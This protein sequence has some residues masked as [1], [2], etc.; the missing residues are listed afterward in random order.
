MAAHNTIKDLGCEV[1][2]DFL[3]AARTCVETRKPDGSILGYPATLILLA[4]MDA[5]G[6]GLSVGK[7]HTRLVVLLHPPF[8]EKLAKFDQD[9]SERPHV[10]NLTKWY[11][12]M[13]AHSGLIAPGVAL[14]P[15]REGAPFGFTGGE[16]TT[17]RVPVLYELVRDVW[18]ELKHTFTPRFCFGEEKGWP[19]SPALIGVIS[20][21]SGL[22]EAGIVAAIKGQ[23]FT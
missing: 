4:A 23:T 12:N 8:S 3:M 19:K 17:I 15:E 11:R 16:L 21:V 14:T 22:T 10:K 20:G 1:I 9:L 7:G 18:G 2:E 13:L 5:I 6:H